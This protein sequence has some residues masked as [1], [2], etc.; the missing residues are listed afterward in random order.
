VAASVR[1]LSGVATVPTVE[2]LADF[3]AIVRLSQLPANSD[4]GVLTALQS[5]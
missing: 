1:A 2:M 4:A 3:D 5:R